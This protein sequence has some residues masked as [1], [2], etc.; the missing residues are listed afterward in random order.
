MTHTKGRP[1]A[2]TPE[3]GVRICELLADG[4]TL[5]SIC[6]ENEDLPNERT[7]R[8]W[9]LDKESPFGRQYT[10]AREIGYHAMADGILDIADANEGPDKQ[11]SMTDRD[12]LRVDA[13]KWLLSKALPKVYGDKLEMQHAP[14]DTFRAMW[15]HISNG[16]RKRAQGLGEPD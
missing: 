4:Q 15:E 5:T 7:V 3:L 14:T 10:Q 8:R 11:A 12:R 6:R 2:F 1:T 9:A 13:R 16:G